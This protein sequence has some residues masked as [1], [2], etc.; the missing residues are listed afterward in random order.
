MSIPL[1]WESYSFPQPLGESVRAV[2]IYNEW[3]SERTEEVGRGGGGRAGGGTIGWAKI[4]FAYRI[5]FFASYLSTGVL[6]HVY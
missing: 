6:S 5:Y 4:V 2:L 3:K 1:A